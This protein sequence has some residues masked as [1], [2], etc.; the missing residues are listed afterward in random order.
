MGKTN[1]GGVNAGLFMTEKSERSPP[2]SATSTPTA[3]TSSADISVGAG[4]MQPRDDT[5]FLL[6][7]P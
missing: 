7:D 3:S 1:A 5:V 2:S 6:H 4:L